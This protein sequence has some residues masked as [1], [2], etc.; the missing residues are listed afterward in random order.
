MSLTEV[1][2]GNKRRAGIPARFLP[3]A[4]QVATTKFSC[5]KGIPLTFLGT[6]CTHGVIKREQNSELL[7]TESMPDT[8]YSEETIQA[9]SKK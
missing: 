1:R 8:H 2:D 4:E 7:G 6:A 5:L 9:C 3:K